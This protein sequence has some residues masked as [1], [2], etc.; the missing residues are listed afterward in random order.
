MVQDQL[1]VCPYLEGVTARM[2][3]RLP[4][5]TVTPEV[6]DQMLALG[7]R[8]SGDFVYRAQ[9]PTCRECRP[10]R[11][12]VSLFQPTSS[13]RRVINRGDR[14]LTWRWASPS[15]DSKRI[16]LFNQHRVARGLGEEAIDAEAYRSFLSDTCCDTS[17]LAIYHRDELVAVS[18]VDIGMTSTSAVYT[19][20]DPQASRY[21][22]GTYAILRQIEWARENGRQYVYLGMF[23]AD[24][25]HLNYKA[26]FLPQQRLIEGRWYEFNQHGRSLEPSSAL[27]PS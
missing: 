8:R 19:H 10:T 16:W 18:I 6:T 12:D 3:L 17:E 22:L 2:P 4:V 11:I 23:V 24:N 27:N 15:V 26:R 21:S 5:G 7:Y 9:C 1:Q 14:E 20:F 25:Q 13:M